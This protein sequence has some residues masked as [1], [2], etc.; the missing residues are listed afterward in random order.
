MILKTCSKCGKSGEY[1][2]DIQFCPYCGAEFAAGVS[3]SVVSGSESPA[4]AAEKMSAG[5]IEGIPWENRGKFGFFEALFETWKLSC[6]SPSAFYRRMA[7]SGGVWRPLAYGL[8][9]A[10]IGFVFQMAYTVIFD[11]LFDLSDWWT[12]PY[13]DLDYGLQ[14]LGDNLQ[15][16]SNLASII[17]FPFLATAG[18]F[19]WSGLVHLVLIIFGWRT[20]DYEASFRVIAY[21][22]GPSA[23]EVVPIIGGVVAIIWQIVLAIVGFRETH[24]L[25]TAKA[26]IAVILPA[27]SFCLCCCCF[28]FWILSMV[29]LAWR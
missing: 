14:S 23:F 9:F 17:V 27:A 29:G 1:E 25:T 8:I 19:I 10:F 21:S 3:G 12:S 22:E 13:G 24:G 4:L 16:I 26:T 28:V 5:R 18:F 20:K 6:F 11:Q 15:S 2:T 7:V